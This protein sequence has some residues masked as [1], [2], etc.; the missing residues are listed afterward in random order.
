MEIM[1]MFVKNIIKKS[2]EFLGLKNVV[3]YIDGDIELSDEVADDLSV[4]TMAVNMTNNNIASSYVELVDAKEIG[5]NSSGKINYSDITDCSIIGIKNV[6]TLG[7]DKVNFKLYPDGVKIDGV[8][9]VK[10]EYSYFPKEVSFEDNINHYLK[11]NELTFAIG[12]V[13]EYLYIKGELD[14]ANLWD[15]RFKQ[16][17]FNILRSKRNI[18]LPARR[19]E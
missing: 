2:A 10:V 13:G 12:V 7:G 6:F 5:C 4:F 18:I 15:R 14:N 16:N 1:V 8:G 3:K 17:M 9:M 19:W 11:V